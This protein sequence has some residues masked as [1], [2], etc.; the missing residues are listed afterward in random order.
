MNNDQFQ[1]RH[2]DLFGTAFEGALPEGLKERKNGVLAHGE[3][4]GHR[5]RIEDPSKAQVF[6]ALDGLLYVR[7]IE[8]TRIVHEEHK[9]ITLAP[10]VY[11]VYAQR[12]YVP[13]AVPRSV[14]D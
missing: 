14:A 11:R 1:F 12:E 3:V 6:E 7:V 4:T 8:E 9:P 13:K 10:G 5:H 2:G